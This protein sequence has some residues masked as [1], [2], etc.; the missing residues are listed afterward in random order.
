M[1]NI[2]NTFAMLLVIAS[3]TLVQAQTLP[4]TLTVKNEEYTGVIYKERD[5]THV[6][7]R[8]DSGLASVLI[9]DLPADI[10]KDFPV[11]SAKTADHLQKDLKQN[12]ELAPVQTV[13]A[14]D[15]VASVHA[16][17]EEETGSIKG[18]LTLSKSD[19]PIDGKLKLFV[20][21]TEQLRME[22]SSPDIQE[23]INV[24]F[25]PSGTTQ[26][27]EA[28]KK[29]LEWSDKAEYAKL[30]TEK[31]VK[32]IPCLNELGAVSVVF[33]SHDE[34][35]TCFVKLVYYDK[36]L[37]QVYSFLIYTGF[38]GDFISTV[39]YVPNAAKRAKAR[40]EAKKE[41]ILK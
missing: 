27:L 3:M 38:L 20:T 28:L 14:K 1:K 12:N 19:K 25:D 39:E 13:A 4:K 15:P 35:R 9:A 22:C 10:Q 2:N 32:R 5:E 17:I 26:L 6:K 11:D 7:F 40:E 16:D 41:D 8:H 29:A 37:D 31:E 34:G 18:S 33:R 21:S 24:V 23:K 30:E 36:Q